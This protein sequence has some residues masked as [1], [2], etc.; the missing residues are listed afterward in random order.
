[1]ITVPRLNSHAQHRP[2]Q[3]LGV[4]LPVSIK[5]AIYAIAPEIK[6][7]S[8]IATKQSDCSYRW[9]SIY[10]KRQE[11][12]IRGMSVDALRC[13]QYRNLKKGT[14]TPDLVDTTDV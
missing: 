3:G 14:A 8:R 2:S 13:Y 12:Q 6:R 10:L 1:M 11:D 5:N 7:K 4:R 9:S